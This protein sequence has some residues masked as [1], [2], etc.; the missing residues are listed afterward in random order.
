MSDTLPPEQHTYLAHYMKGVSRSFSLVAPEVD[1]P[2]EDYLATAYLICRVVDNIEDTTQPFEWQQARFA[3]LAELLDYPQ[4]AEAVL[5][6]WDRLAWPGLTDSEK[7]LMTIKDGLMLWQTYAQISD[8]YRAPIRHWAGVMAFGM[9]RS[10]NPT[11]SDY[12]FTQ[13]DV[14]LPLLESDYDLY[15][16]Y[17][18]GT[19]GR[20]ITELAIQFYDVGDDSAQILT[21]GSDACG[22]ALQKTNIVK[23]FAADLE[24]GVCYLPGEWLRE[25]DYAPLKLRNVPSYWKKKVLLNVVAEIEDSVDYVLA[26]P[27]TAVGYRRA[28]LMMMLPAFETILL[29]ARLLPDLFTPNHAVKISRKKMGQC[30]L[31]ARKMATDDEAIQAYARDMSRQIRSELGMVAAGAH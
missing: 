11:T 30:V 16:F 1:S 19:V 8:V 6:N 10:G 3:E 2:L 31:R 23:D 27:K 15:C 14:R 13:G 22:R 9:E 24:R 4:K 5:A 20:M 18:A 29:A 26:M 25:I 28:G 17:V 12:F 7:E 21:D